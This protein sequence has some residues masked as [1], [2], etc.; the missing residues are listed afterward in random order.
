MAAALKEVMDNIA[1]SLGNMYK[2]CPYRLAFVH[3][4][5]GDAR[6]T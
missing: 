4:G 5:D 1:N 6:K 2:V 3:S